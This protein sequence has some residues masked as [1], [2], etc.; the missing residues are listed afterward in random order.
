MTAT[1][2]YGLVGAD[3]KLPDDLTGLGPSGTVS[4]IAHGDVAAIVS[5]VQTDRPLGTRDDLLAH[6][7]VV[8]AVEQV[9]GG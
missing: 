6:E 1:Y 8:D 4:T 3:A 7:T 9:A 2:V 5:D